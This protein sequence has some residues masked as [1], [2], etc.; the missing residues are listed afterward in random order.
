[1]NTRGKGGILALGLFASMIAASASGAAV[2]L[3]VKMRG[4]STSDKYLKADLF[5]LLAQT[6]VNVIRLGFS[7]DSPNPNLPTPQNPLAPYTTNL[8]IL[9]AALPLAQAAGIK[10]ILCAAETYGWSPDVFQGSA[11][12]LATYRTNLATFWT[13]MAQRYVNE[14]AIVAYDVLNEPKTDWPSR[15]QWY[16]NVMP[17]AVAAIR[18]VNS[19]IWL[20]VESEYQAAA[21]GFSTMPVLN[22]SNVI[23]SFHF[24]SPHSY[25]HQG[26]LG[27]AGYAAT[28]PGSNSMWGTA[29]YA[30]WDIETLRNEM[31]EV[32]N[33]ATAHPDQRI[34][35]GEFGVLRWAAGADKWLGD[36]IELFEEYGWDWCNHS[37]SGWNGFNVTYAPD[38]QSTSQLADGGDRGA[39]WTV[40]HQWFSFNQLDAYGIPSGWKT[41]YFGS[42]NAVNGGA[43]DDWDHD[44]MLNW[45]EYLAGTVPTNASSKFQVTDFKRPG[46]TNFVIQWSSVA[47]KKY[48]LQTSTNLLAGFDGWATNHVPAT[49]PLNTHTVIGD[50]VHRRYYRVMVQP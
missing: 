1:M 12:D 10:I 26:I 22:D 39:R 36:C 43:Q 15:G 24:Y 49:P 6:D 38:S 47:G 30:F 31:L 5:A 25:C 33:L 41:Q 19:N 16:T 9:D 37:P 23:Y 21:G 17:A 44:G 48:A 7:V 32:I 50:Q 20:V 46:G 34:L 2:E 27:Y 28:Y 8:A 11:A 35:V 3:P 4:I 40:L 29:P 13:A 18:S 14:P 42:T 45:Q